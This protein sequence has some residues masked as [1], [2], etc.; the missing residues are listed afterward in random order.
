VVGALQ[1]IRTEGEI[2]QREG[3]I[4]G[5][6]AKEQR[7]QEGRPAH[8]DQV[9]VGMKVAPGAAAALHVEAAVPIDDAAVGGA[10]LLGQ[11]GVE[12]GLVHTDQIT[13][14]RR[15]SHGAGARDTINA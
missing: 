6:V 3:G 15:G 10:E 9:Q 5:H 2:A 8:V 12:A 7:Q 13:R 14:N 1:L 4:G 11:P